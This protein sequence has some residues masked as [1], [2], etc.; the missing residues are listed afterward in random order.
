MN[1]KEMSEVLKNNLQIMEII[2]LSKKL[3]NKK[4]TG[5]LDTILE[6]LP[7]LDAIELEQ[8]RIEI[9]RMYDVI[10]NEAIDREVY[11]DDKNE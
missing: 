10:E 6:L 1:K 8:L 11:G 3:I 7:E 9:K 2:E 4:K 5:Y